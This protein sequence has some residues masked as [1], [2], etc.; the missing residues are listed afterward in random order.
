MGAINEAEK[1][2][3][4]DHARIFSLAT[5]DQMSAKQIEDINYT[6]MLKTNLVPFIKRR[7]S[8]FSTG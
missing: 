8:Y 5:K 3:N 2:S 1:A 7:K 4:R 6:E